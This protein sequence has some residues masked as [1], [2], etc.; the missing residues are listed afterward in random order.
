M[1][2]TYTYINLCLLR[3][4]NTYCLRHAKETECNIDH[5]LT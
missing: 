5:Q 4:I 2:H 3:V 1:T